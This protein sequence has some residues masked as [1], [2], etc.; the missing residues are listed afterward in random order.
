MVCTPPTTFALS[1]VLFGGNRQCP[2]GDIVFKLNISISSYGWGRRRCNT[3]TGAVVLMVWRQFA[4]RLFWSS[5]PALPFG[6]A[7]FLK[8]FSQ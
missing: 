1:L 5:L 4:F 6:K 3:P 7:P 8:P 2:I